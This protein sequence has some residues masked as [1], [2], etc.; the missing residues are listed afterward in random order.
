MWEDGAGRGRGLA[1]SWSAGGEPSAPGGGG[2]GSEAQALG[3][4]G[5]GEEKGMHRLLRCRSEEQGVKAWFLTPPSRA[6]EPA[7][8]GRGAQREGQT[9]GP[10]GRAGRWGAK[11]ALSPPLR[12]R[13]CQV[14]CLER[15]TSKIRPG[16]KGR[17]KERAWRGLGGG[18]DSSAPSPAR[19]A[20]PYPGRAR[21]RRSGGEPGRLAVRA[22][23]SAGPAAGGRAGGCL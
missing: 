6:L 5:E 21:R 7:P 9:Q 23:Q 10:A 4:C 11:P 20:R 8:T 22:H 1:V 17:R 15:K 2:G 19:S 3:G 12:A 14:S 13:G 18:P 16:K